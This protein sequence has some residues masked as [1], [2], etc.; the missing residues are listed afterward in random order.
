MYIKGKDYFI[1]A[2]GYSEEGKPVSRVMRKQPLSELE[3]K[4]F[5]IP[6]YTHPIIF[7]WDKCKYMVRRLKIFSN[8]IK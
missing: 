3:K 1:G 4:F 2:I 8:R 6:I 5:G 7:Q